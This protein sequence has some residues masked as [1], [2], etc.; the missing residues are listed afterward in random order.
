MRRPS[1]TPGPHRQAALLGDLAHH[2]LGHGLPHGDLAAGQG[3]A[4]DSVAA[5]PG[6]H[7]TAAG[8]H[9]DDH[10]LVAALF[11][12]GPSWL[13]LPRFTAARFALVRIALAG[14]ASAWV[15]GGGQGGEDGGL[16]SGGVGV[17]GQGSQ[18]RCDPPQLVRLRQ[19]IDHLLDGCGEV[20]EDLRD[21]GGHRLEVDPAFGRDP[22]QQLG[23]VTVTGHTAAFCP[24]DVFGRGR[25]VQTCA[26]SSHAPGAP[27]TPGAH[28][29][30]T[31]GRQ[32]G[33]S[34]PSSGL[35]RNSGA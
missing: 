4:R 21:G 14:V 1:S 22:H 12:P 16:E 3:P 28:S 13:A 10:H 18:R 25:S 5:L 2:R 15:G 19:L 31:S 6:Q 7:A 23:P 11:R 17:V 8:D 32:P 30:R 24:H 9:G 29:A 33:G 34:P 26:S 35:P 20:R 27:V